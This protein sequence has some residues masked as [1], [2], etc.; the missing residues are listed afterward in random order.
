ME[1]LQKQK[2]LKQLSRRNIS[3]FCIAQ[4]HHKLLQILSF[5]VNIIENFDSLTTSDVDIDDCADYK[6]LIQIIK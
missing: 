2:L 5:K 1:D 3:H 6:M 4:L